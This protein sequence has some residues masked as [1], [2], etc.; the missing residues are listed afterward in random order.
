MKESGIIGRFHPAGKLFI[1]FLIVFISIAVISFLG[2]MLA[3][4][5]F[6][7][8]ILSVLEG[9]QFDSIEG[10]QLINFNKY[11][12]FVSHIG[13]FIVPSLAFAWLVKGNIVEYF[14]FNKKAD[15]RQMFLGVCIVFASLPLI[16]LLV[17]INMQLSLPSY[18]QSLEEWMISAEETAMELT[19]KFLNVETPAGLI[20]NIFI[21]AI[22]PAIGEE[23]IFRGVL[24][25]TL[26]QWTKSSHLAVWISAII[27]S[28]MHIQ[29][30]GFLPRLFLGVL[31]G[32]LVVYSGSLWIAIL[33]HFVNNAA[34]VIAYYYYHN[35]MSK[36]QLDEIGTG[37]SGV[38]FVLVSVLL[39]SLLM[40]AYWKIG[41]HAN[42]GVENNKNHIL[43]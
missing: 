6:D 25:R 17:E 42:A 31:F 37:E 28:A 43:N 29:F 18:L 3:V 33:V 36:I 14:R 24:M 5:F 23:L 10:Q 40:F 35:K 21:I 16:N 15:L 2:M 27:F 38:Y 1:L 39:V 22:V 11:L 41:K 13:L 7:V 9:A 26:K 20:T 4:P 30:F 19:E 12:Q 32:Y 34:A 8:S